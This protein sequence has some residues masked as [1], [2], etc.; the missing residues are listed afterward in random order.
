FA[1][2]AVSAAFA[3]LFTFLPSFVFIFLSGPLVE[4]THGD[5]RFTAPLTGITAAVV[6]VILN[7]ALFFAYHVMLP[8]GRGVEWASVVIGLAAVVALF[9][10]KVGVIPL[11]VACA[12]AGL[13]RFLL[14]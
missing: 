14:G 9:R 5:L 11:I 1:A 10:Y 6:G 7:L 8:Q 4:A 2:V 12:A 13:G 3:T